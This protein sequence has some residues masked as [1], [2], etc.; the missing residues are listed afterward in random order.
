MTREYLEKLFAVGKQIENYFDTEKYTDT[1]GTFWFG[2]GD[3]PD[4][5]WMTH[6]PSDGVLTKA[7]MM[8]KMCRELLDKEWAKA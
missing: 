8:R 3:D 6:S 1:D 4:E 2:H 5:V 7:Q